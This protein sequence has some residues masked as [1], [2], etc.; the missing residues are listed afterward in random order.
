MADY[1][2]S[3]I[4]G[5]NNIKEWMCFINTKITGIKNKLFGD[6][7][8]NIMIKE[9]VRRDIN[10]TIEE[11]RKEK[12]IIKSNREAKERLIAIKK[13]KERQRLLAIQRQ[14]EKIRREKERLEKER[15]MKLLKERLEKERLERI[16]KERI[17]KEKREKE[18][19]NKQV[20]EKYALIKNDL[21]KPF[22]LDDIK[23]E[24]LKNA[25]NEE[26]L[27]CL[28]KFELNQQ[29]L[30]LC[31][32]HLFHSTCIMRWLLNHEECP[33]C[34]CNYKG[35][36]EEINNPQIN[37]TGNNGNINNHNTQLN[38]NNNNL[39]NNINND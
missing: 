30:Y 23:L 5:Y 12:E 38:F 2:K 11:R 9:T 31:C 8:I 16:E 13:E 33:I 18:R 10:N 7:E 32:M 28:E 36:S 25:K 39:N 17:E 1:L 37:M 15:R 4:N 20:N 29:C 34:K 22:F 6:S 24:K 3:V 14:Q 19:I 21:P 35:K 27:I 26:C